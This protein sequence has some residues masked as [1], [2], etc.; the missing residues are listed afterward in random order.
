MTN[1]DRAHAAKVRRQLNRHGR[2]PITLPNAH[3]RRILERQ[4]HILIL[5][6]AHRL[7]LKGAPKLYDLHNAL[8]VKRNTAHRA[9]GRLDLQSDPHVLTIELLEV[10]PTTLQDIQLKDARAAGFPT[11]A[12]L[13][14]DWR[15]H[16]RRSAPDAQVF[17]HRFQIEGARYLH[18]D[19]HR[20]YTHDPA[21][22]V[23][24][25]LAAPSAT[26]LDTMATDNRER[27]EDGR[28][29]E[30]ERRSAKSLA[31]RLKV[32]V[33]RADEAAIDS[34]LRDLEALKQRIAA[35]AA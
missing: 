4:P 1:V 3:V 12:D 22:G 25:E 17:L 29:D 5:T 8:T 20:G 24:G 21:E 33:G 6:R 2:F 32:A 16:H 11:V 19:I 7:G 14:D 28:R 30:M 23:R 27:F 35:K 18:R 9:G 26:E 34:I 13:L 31:A 10:T 15:D